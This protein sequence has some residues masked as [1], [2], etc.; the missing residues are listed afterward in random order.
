M[1]L[2]STVSLSLLAVCVALA[3]KPNSPAPGHYYRM[4]LVKIMDEQGFGQPVEVA[5][6][7]VPADW[8]TE[9]GVQ[10]DG[11]QLGCP[12]NIIKI[13]FRAASPDGLS[14]VE[15]SPGFT[16]QAASD[17]QMQQILR[18]QA[19]SRTGCGVGPVSGSIDYLRQS[20]IPQLRP[21]ARILGSE[22]LP[23]VAQA[24]QTQLA[25]AYGPLVQ[26]GYVK[27]YRA[28]SGSVRIA[29]NQNGQGVEEALSTTILSVAMPSANTA[30]LMQGQV[31]M[32]ASTFTMI[33]EGV[34]GARA[35]AGKFDNKLV[36]TILASTRPNPQYQA[37]V[38]QFLSNMN[39]IAQKGAMDRARIWQE[40]GRQISATISQAYQN[41]QAV[42][43]R[44]AQQFS[45]AIRGVETYVNPSNGTRVELSG[46]YDNAWVNGRE[47]YLLSDSPAFNPG[48]V[49]Q[50][51]WT[52]LKKVR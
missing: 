1:K 26:A 7:L 48:V 47:E 12:M 32:T 14:G 25:E 29:Y 5:R 41:Q 44:A 43:D 16:W 17:P 33:A 40:A 27:G 2:G 10:W 11:Q 49:L 13:R 45:Q 19:M 28:D 8:R 46:G 50:E 22:P 23:A 39:A 31:R 51:N 4:K 36:A 24:K 9:G 21:G 30:A 18:Q 42:Q 6:L 34:F 3:Q 38:S 35:P 37:A 20:V 15:I 52:E